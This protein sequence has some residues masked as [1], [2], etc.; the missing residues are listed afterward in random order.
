MIRSTEAFGQRAMRVWPASVLPSP[1]IRNSPRSTASCLWCQ[2]VGSLLVRAGARPE[3]GIQS[4]LEGGK[5]CNV[6]NDL[7]AQQSGDRSGPDTRLNCQTPKG[8]LTQRCPQSAGNLLRDLRVLRSFGHQLA[9]R[10]GL[11]RCQ[12]GRGLPGLTPAHTCPSSADA[13]TSEHTVGTVVSWRTAAPQELQVCYSF[14]LWN[15]TAFLLVDSQVR[16]CGES[17]WAARVIGGVI[18][19]TLW[20]ST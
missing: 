17:E 16:V 15:T 13:Q 12:P 18:A 11:V 9:I 10:P 19:C 20:T 2:I 8:P 5:R 1:G 6:R 3:P 14:H 4:S 7:S